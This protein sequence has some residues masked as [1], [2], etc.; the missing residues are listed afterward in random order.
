LTGGLATG[1]GHLVDDRTESSADEWSE[2]AVRS[3]ALQLAAAQASKAGTT[4]ATIKTRMYGPVLDLLQ[5]ALRD[6]AVSRVGSCVRVFARRKGSS[7]KRI[8]RY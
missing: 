8:C 6:D 4:L 5:S 1:S 3:T 2:D 7:A